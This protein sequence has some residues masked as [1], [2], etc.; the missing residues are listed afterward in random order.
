MSRTLLFEASPRQPADASTTTLR[1]AW[2]ARQRADF[3]GAQWH[4]IVLAPPSF[5]T[6]LG[7]DGQVFAARPTPQVGQLAIIT[8][9]GAAGASGLVWKGA[10]VTLRAAAWPRGTADAADGDFAT[11]WRGEVEEIAVAEGLATLTLIDA[12]KALREPLANTKFGGTGIALLD[13]ATADRDPDQVVPRAFGQLRSLPG[14]LVDRLNNIWM[15]ARDPATSVQ[16]VYDGGAAFTLGVA[17]ANLAALQGTV[18]ARGA[19]DYCL[20]AG[21]VFLVR[22][23]D[24][25]VYP[26]TCDA[27]FGATKAGEIAEAIVTG[28]TSL[29]FRSGVLAAYNSAQPAACGIFVEDDASIATVLDRL[30]SGLGSWWKVRSS[31]EIDLRQWGVGT[32][33]LTVPAA[34][35]G[36]PERLRVLPPTGRRTLGYARNNR[37]HSESEIAQILLADR[38]AYADGTSIEDLKPAGPGATGGENLIA[39][40]LLLNGT[41]GW[42]TLSGA[43]IPVEGLV[44]DPANYWQFPARPPGQGDRTGTNIF[45]LMGAKKLYV[46]G[47]AFT[48]NG[49]GS[50]DAILNFFD[51]T[52]AL[53]LDAPPQGFSL[54]PA[55]TN[56][57][58]PFETE[59]E[60]PAGMTQARFEA[61]S[62]S[63]TAPCNV[64]VVRVSSTQRSADQTALA[65]ALIVPPADQ[66]IQANSAGT[67]ISG[68]LPRT[69][70]AS[71][72]RN[73]ADIS[74]LASLS[75]ETAITSAGIATIAS[76]GEITLNNPVPG[77]VI[78]ITGSLNGRALTPAQFNVAVNIPPPSSTGTGGAGPPATVSTFIT[79]PASTSYVV[80]TATMTVRVGSAGTVTCTAPID[81]ATPG[82]GGYGL[83][84]KWRYRVSPSGSWNDAGSAIDEDYPTEIYADYYFYFEAPGRITVNQ[85]VTGLTPGTDYDFEL[86]MA[87]PVGSIARILYGTCVVTPS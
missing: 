24:K 79:D 46:S 25:P 86:R 70:K 30:F 31:G 38:L 58:T 34:K 63:L 41:T 20:N 17:R 40:S 77:G 2:K 81:F 67:P 82:Y 4:P 80:V 16:G 49:A 9:G 21:G 84:G 47:V 57:W 39:N 87:V 29:T 52:G 62:L 85:T 7:W 83:L 36:A 8:R 50:F 60:V 69:I 23:W 1:M 15:F 72:I 74:T 12:G 18:P 76:D 66:T 65:L 37:V 6:S 45:D 11:V 42:I 64:C 53:R 13:A 19:V 44:T 22:P 43:P 54:M 27:T 14:L 71:V 28:R 78:R 35:R 55:V 32:P 33:A 51:A 26:L 48:V 56:A 68:Q 61:A 5:Q 3:L 75:L 10:A 73:G 59:I